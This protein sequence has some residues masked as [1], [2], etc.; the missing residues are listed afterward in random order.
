MIS[1]A[2]FPDT[3]LIPHP[4]SNAGSLESVGNRLIVAF[5][6]IT[7][8]RLPYQAEFEEACGAIQG[9]ALPAGYVLNNASRWSPTWVVYN[10]E[11]RAEWVNEG[12]FAVRVLSLIY[13]SNRPSLGTGRMSVGLKLTRRQHSV[14]QALSVR[15]P[16]TSLSS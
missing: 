8:G 6:F 16:L 7:A 5:Q 13:A 11:V 15:Y 10:A 4:N 9:S 1:T 14:V 12:H 3:F 2:Q